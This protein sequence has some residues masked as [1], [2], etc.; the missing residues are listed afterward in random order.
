VYPGESS[1][2]TGLHTPFNGPDKYYGLSH[3]DFCWDDQTPP[4]DD[5]TPPPGDQ[6]PPAAPPAVQPPATGDV[7]P[8]QVV[9]GKSR[10]LG[11]SGCAG[12]KVKA[13]VKGSRI[14]KVTFL[15]DGKKVKVVKGAGSYSVKTSKLKGGVHHIKARVVYEAGAATRSRTHIVTF[16][17][18]IKRKIVPRFAG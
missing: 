3:V 10:L 15:L 12:K 16:Q 1:G 14:A 18:C 13:T 5:E 2:D 17:R 4:P 7:L 9:A 8:A 11:P 6:T